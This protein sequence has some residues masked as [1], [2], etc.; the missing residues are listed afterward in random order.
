MRIDRDLS[1]LET[2]RRDTLAIVLTAVASARP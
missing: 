2:T 1:E